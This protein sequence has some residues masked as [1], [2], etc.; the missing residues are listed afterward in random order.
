MS[1]DED[2]FLAY[3]NVLVKK[4]KSIHE[5]KELSLNDL[6]SLYNLVKTSIS[7]I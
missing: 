1:I 3:K 6:S 4:I 2:K 5:L 7:K